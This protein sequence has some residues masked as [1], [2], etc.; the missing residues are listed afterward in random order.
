[1][2]LC[3][4]SNPHPEIGIYA[5]YLV[6]VKGKYMWFNIQS[7]S[8]TLRKVSVVPGGKGGMEGESPGNTP[9]C[10]YYIS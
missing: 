8:D 4:T 3:V 7:M 10:V 9:H 2:L 5:V 6:V 1:M